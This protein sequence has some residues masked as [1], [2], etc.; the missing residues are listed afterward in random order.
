MINYLAKLSNISGYILR[1]AQSLDLQP[2][3]GSC[4]LKSSSGLFCPDLQPDPETR[5]LEVPDLP[6]RPRQHGAHR[7]Q[8]PDAAGG[9]AT[10]RDVPTRQTSQLQFP[11][12]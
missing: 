5:G 7:V 12:Q 10:P 4:S 11:D 6:V 8:H 1:V 2:G 9:R 3:H